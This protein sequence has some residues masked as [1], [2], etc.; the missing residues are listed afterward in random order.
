M[1]KIAI[2]KSIWINA[3]REKVWRAITDPEQI[4]KWFSPGMKWR[5]DGLHVGARMAIYDPE[6]NIDL[7]IQEVEV[8]DPPNQ[9]VTRS[10]V[11]L[12]ETPH[13]TTW[14]LEDEN[15]GTRLTLIHSGYEL[16][17]AAVR[18]KNLLQNG[19]GFTMV[20]ENI[21]AHVEGRPLPVPGG[22]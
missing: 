1:E 4:A 7:I 13:V 18:E 8:A 5:S 11:S 10:I 17:P 19:A 14:K 12:P 15:G 3:S 22:F 16:E 9:L 2:E 20:L 6:T 21:K